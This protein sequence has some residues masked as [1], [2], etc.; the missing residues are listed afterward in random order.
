[1]L[2]SKNAIGK[3]PEKKNIGE[4]KGKIAFGKSKIEEFKRK[5]II[6][7]SRFYKK[8]DDKFTEILYGKMQKDMR[9]IK[10]FQT[11]NLEEYIRKKADFIL[12]NKD[13]WVRDTIKDLEKS[14]ILSG[15]NENCSLVEIKHKAFVEYIG[16]EKVIS[17]LVFRAM[18]MDL[19][20][21]KVYK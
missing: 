20:V 16:Q 21:K 7:G 4:N 14:G 9:E 12:K 15:K 5:N 1:M 11:S 3:E 2:V 13:L 17:Q 18:Q 8:L 6:I 19:P 10:K